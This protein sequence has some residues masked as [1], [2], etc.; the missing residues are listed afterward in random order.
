MALHDRD[1]NRI[2][3]TP[4]TRKL[5]DLGSAQHIA[6]FDRQDVVNNFQNGFE[7]R[8]DCSVALDRPITVQDFL[9]NLGVGDESLL[10]EAVAR[11][12][13]IW[14]SVLRGCGAPTRYIGMFESIKITLDSRARSRP[15]SVQCRRL[16]MST[17]PPYESP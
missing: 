14:L 13:R 9:E 3:G 15:T 16:E 12:S 4:V 7:S 6:L 2:A 8:L 17:W 5:Q 10:K 1:M 11:S